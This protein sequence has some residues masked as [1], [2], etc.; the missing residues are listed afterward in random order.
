MLCG[1]SASDLLAFGFRVVHAGFYMGADHGEFRL[2]EYSGHL[3]K[4]LTIC[5]ELAKSMHRQY[6]VCRCLDFASQILEEEGMA[7]TLCVDQTED[8]VGFVLVQFDGE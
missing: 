5:L 7:C 2:A 6:R 8:V 3:Q 1:S 4:C